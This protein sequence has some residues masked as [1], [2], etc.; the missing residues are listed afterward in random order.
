MVRAILRAPSV[1]ESA[2]FDF[3]PLISL[4][5]QIVGQYEARMTLKPPKSSQ[6]LA[7][8]RRDY[9]AIARQLDL[10]AHADRHQ[11]RGIIELVRDKREPDQDLR[12]YVPVAV[13]SLF[14]PAFAPWLAAELGANSV[15]GNVLALE[16][17][18]GEMRT[19]L[20][21]LRAALDSLQR[22][23][24]RLVID[25]NPAQGTDIEK[26][27]A[28][29]AFSA[30][31]LRRSGSAKTAADVAWEPWSNAISHAKSLG[32]IVVAADIAGIAD[33]STLLRQGVHYVQGEPI[34]T[35]LPGWTFDFSEAVS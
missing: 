17:D 12:L 26:L 27:L 9:L 6:P 20:A 19:R 3:Q 4:S 14:D 24:V 33:L 29:D 18:A 13:E 2:Q 11:L 21:R 16:L 22:I 7:L 1:S 34:C 15:P 23:G 25:A 31:K 10:V 30:V 28:I 8:E 32:K 5:G 35:W